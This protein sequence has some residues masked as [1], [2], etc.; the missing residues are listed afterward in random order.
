MLSYYQTY[1]ELHQDPAPSME[2]K[3][4]AVLLQ[5]RK[6]GAITPLYNHLR[7]SGGQTP[8]VYGL[9]KV[10]KPGFPLRPIMS[11]F[12]SPSYKLSK[13]LSKLLSPLVGNSESFVKNSAEF[14]SFIRSQTI[15]PDESLVL[16]DVVSLFM[17]VP[18]QLALSVASRR[19]SSDNTLSSRTNLS[20]SEFLSL[21]EFCLNATYLCFRGCFFKQI[22][23]TVMGSLVSVTIAN[24]V[25]EDVES[26]ALTSYDIHL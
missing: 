23:G 1:C 21:L 5:L 14:S 7:S 18:V 26:C 17:N 6:K 10:H 22:Y 16:F 19:L 20:V 11:F 4:N 25:M 8:L 15:S 2:R 3:L 13:Y 12:S 24:L 9:P